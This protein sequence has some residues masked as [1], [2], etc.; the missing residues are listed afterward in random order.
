METPQYRPLKPG[1]AGCW[2][3]PTAR[4]AQY[5]GLAFV[6]AIMGMFIA[7]LAGGLQT[8]VV[9]DHMK[10]G[11]DDMNSQM[12]MGADAAAKFVTSLKGKFP[13]NQPEVTTRQMLGI[14]ENAHKI[15]ARVQYL[16]ENVQPAAIG[17]TVQNINKILGALTPDDVETIKQKILSI[18]AHIDADIASIPADKVAALITTI[19]K[20]DSEKINILIDN[21]SKLHEIKIQI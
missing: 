3:K 1:R 17:L 18:T 14:V 10:R 7:L 4:W 21:I 15:S 8:T 12:K 5:V 6:A 2:Y 13:V 19:S 20:L 16:L 11:M 9:M